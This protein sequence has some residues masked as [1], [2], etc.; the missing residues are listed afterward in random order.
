MS[1]PERVCAACHESWP[2]DAEFYNGDS[3]RCHACVDERRP[4]PKQRG[5]RTPE[6]EREYQRQKY[7]RHRERY[8]AGMRKWYAANREEH[9]ARR[10][11]K[12]KEAV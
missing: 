11:A 6:K 9:N 1:T 8:K 4:A 7:A 12:R 3:P 10:R 2:A 5:Y